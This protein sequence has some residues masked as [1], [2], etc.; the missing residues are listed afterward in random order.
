MKP[1]AR[2]SAEYFLL[3]ST[4]LLLMGG[5]NPDLF[6][7]PETFEAY[8]TQDGV[9]FTQLTDMPFRSSHIAGGK[10]TTD[11]QFYF[12][13]RNGA[14]EKLVSWKLNPDTLAW[15][16][17]N[18]D[19]NAGDLAGL[20]SASWGFYINN[21]IY[22]AVTPDF[23]AV[24]L[25][26]SSD[27][28]TW[29]KTCD[30]PNYAIRSRAWVENNLV[31]FSGGGNYDGIVVDN[32]IENIYVSNS[33]ITSF[34]VFAPLPARMRGLWPSFCK[35]G[36][37]WIYIAGLTFDSDNSVREGAVYYS[38]SDMAANTFVL[39]NISLFLTTH[40][41]AFNVM[42]NKVFCFGGHLDDTS[43]IIQL[44]N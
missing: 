12:I 42:D 10:N 32:L 5:W 43:A 28:N 24:E 18:S 33:L 1:T 29:T 7:P 23:I 34:S 36:D 22:Y 39:T 31:Y 37:L 27:G 13:G 14:N 19:L 35:L 41:I 25:W 3:N 15:T 38:R 6:A 17:I 40:A 11:G 30:L 4:T 2:D 9:S 44:A 21:K 20:S 8:T 16:V 26:E